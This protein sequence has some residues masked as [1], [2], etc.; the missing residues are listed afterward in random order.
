MLSSSVASLPSLSSS[1]SLIT[2]SGRRRQVRPHPPLHARRIRGHLRPHHRRS[3]P[4]STQYVFQL[5][6]RTES[7]KRNVKID[8]HLISVCTLPIPRRVFP[9]HSLALP[10]PSSMFCLAAVALVLAR[11]RDE[12]CAKRIAAGLLAASLV[13]FVW[14]Y[15]VLSG[16]PVPDLWAQSLKILPSYGFY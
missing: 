2:H 6:A 11:W 4:Q 9:T 16:L 3:S 1:P 15:P 13:L 8:G 10:P 14:F 5:I 12:R 7:F